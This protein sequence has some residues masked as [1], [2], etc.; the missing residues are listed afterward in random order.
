MPG[1]SGSS[2]SNGSNVTARIKLPR[3]PWVNAL[4]NSKRLADRPENHGGEPI[5]TSI[6]HDAP[7]SGLRRFFAIALLSVAASHGEAGAQPIE[8]PATI[9]VQLELRDGHLAINRDA[10]QLMLV[11]SRADVFKRCKLT[12]PAIRSHLEDYLDGVLR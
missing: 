9:E 11:E 3:P 1:P 2:P 8:A 5:I 12:P 7:G 6:C 4:H 10:T